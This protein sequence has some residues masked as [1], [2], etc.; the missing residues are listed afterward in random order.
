MRCDVAAVERFTVHH[1][2]ADCLFSGQLGTFVSS[3]FQSGY[4]VPLKLMIEGVGNVE[5]K[6]KRVTSP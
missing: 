2:S 4:R 1:C 3:H 5:Q 6:K